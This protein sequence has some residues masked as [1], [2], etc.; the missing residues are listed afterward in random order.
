MIKPTYIDGKKDL[1]IKYDWHLIRKELKKLDIPGMYYNPATAP[2]ESVQW[3]V[4]LSE[5]AVGKTTGWLLLG[6]VMYQLYGTVT[7]YLRS[8][9]DMVAPKNAS[10]LY[11]VIIANDYVIKLTGGTY[12]ALTYKFRKWYLCHIDEDG[13]MDKIDSHYC[14]RVVSLDESMNLKSS[15]N[16]PTADLVIFDEAI[17]VD[18]RYENMQDFVL[19]VDVLSTIFRLREC[20]KIAVLANTINKYAMIL[21]DLCI[22]ER[23]SEMQLSES[24]THVTDRGTKIYIELIGTPK[25]YRTKKQRWTKLFAGFDRPDLAAITGE[26]TWAVKMYQHI[27]QRDSDAQQPKMLYCKLYIYDQNKYIRLDVM[28]DPEIGICMYAHWAT[29]THKDS[30]ILTTADMTDRRY[31]HGI[32]DTCRVGSVIKYMLHSN[33]MFFASN[34]VGAF[35]ENYLVKCGYNTQNLFK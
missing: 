1:G 28:R 25:A 35:F 22:F 31:L 26:S 16:E 17:P 20:G 9:K 32:G 10:S 19:L 7:V 3:F 21:H 5:R 13:N 23:V 12:N 11:S 30:V 34:D 33:R 29:R 18:L 4:E 6:L 27:P 14:C 2:L 15:F 24:C 8:R